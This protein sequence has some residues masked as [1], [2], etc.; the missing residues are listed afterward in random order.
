MKFV[1]E[2]ATMLLA[3]VDSDIMKTRTERSSG[4]A[5]TAGVWWRERLKRFCTISAI[6]YTSSAF[7]LTYRNFFSHVLPKFPQGLTESAMRLALDEGCVR[8]SDDVIGAR[9]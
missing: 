5:S 4:V 9:R 2:A 6:L 1:S 3:L 8:G 7:R